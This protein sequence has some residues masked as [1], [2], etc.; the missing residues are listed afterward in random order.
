M[1]PSNRVETREDFSILLVDD[2]PTVVRVLSRILHNFAPLRFATSGGVALKLARDSTPDL[3]LLDIDMPE[4]SGF[5]VCRTFKSEP[6]LAQV[7]IIFLSG[8]DSPQLETVGLQLGAADFISKP[9]NP[10]LVLARVRTFQR[11]KLLSDTVRTAATLD[12][13][14]GALTRRQFEKVLTREWLRSQRSGAPLA[15]L[16]AEIDGFREY[17]IRVGEERGDA[18]LREVADALRFC[19]R[20]ASDVLGRHAGASFALL[21]PES[22]PESAP[23]VAQRAME[24]VA[25]LDVGLTLSVGGACARIRHEMAGASER[26]ATVSEG[27]PGDLIAAAET[28]LESA[29]GAGGNRTRFVDVAAADQGMFHRRGAQPATK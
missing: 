15:L 11:M 6:A 21:L 7:P 28:A 22:P 10:A 14:T 2:D 19:A 8:H 1:S 25:G 26:R 4:I 3:V 27:V 23:I 16:L 17:N 24:A 20:R 29:K 18:C 12:F 5:D 13:L 9:P